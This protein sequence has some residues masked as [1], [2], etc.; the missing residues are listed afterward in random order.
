MHVLWSSHTSDTSHRLNHVL[1]SCILSCRIHDRENLPARSKE[2][3]AIGSGE[4]VAAGD[5]IDSAACCRLASIHHHRP[6]CP[7]IAIR[8]R[9]CGTGLHLHAHTVG[10][11]EAKHNPERSEPSLPADRGSR[12]YRQESPINA[13]KN[14]IAIIADRLR[15]D[16]GVA[17]PFVRATDHCKWREGTFA[18]L[19]P[20][21]NS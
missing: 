13:A 14:Q 8:L 9:Y 5:A 20:A 15:L 12:D 16:P 4:R 2:W 17:S 7:S 21:L 18:P 11:K 10:K 1:G 19:A 6:I 3:L